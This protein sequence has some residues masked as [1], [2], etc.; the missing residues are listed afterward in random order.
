MITKRP[1]SKSK[2]VMFIDQFGM[3]LELIHTIQ[4]NR[5]STYSYED[6]LENQIRSQPIINYKTINNVEP[7]QDFPFKLIPKFKLFSNEVKLQKNGITLNSIEVYN[8][9]SFV[10]NSSFFQNYF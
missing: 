9:V 8:D 7:A 4:V 3:E 6:N 1:I 10:N 5:N 2:Q